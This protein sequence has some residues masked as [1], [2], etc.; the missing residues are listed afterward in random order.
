MS[1]VV[2]TVGR[3]GLLAR[4]LASLAACDPP[5]A[6]LVVVDQSGGGEV[7]AAVAA[8]AC[9]DARRVPSD[10]RSIGAAL[11][12]GLEA[13]RHDIVAVTHDDCE[14]DPSWAGRA[15]ALAARHPGALLTGRVLAAPGPGHVPS[16]TA[17]ATA[18]D[19][20]GELRDNVLYPANMVLDRRAALAIGGFDSRIVPA[21]EDNDFCY[22]WLR[23]GRPLRFE[24]GLVVW[25]ADWRAPEGLAPLYAGYAR[26]AGLFYAKHLRRRDLRVL[27]FLL[28]D[29]RD[30]AR[31]AA[32]AALRRHPEEVDPRRGLWRG[33]PAGL[34]DGWRL[35]G[36]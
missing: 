29:V 13:A 16:T 33:L 1:V 11:N 10:A 20:T 6:E 9:L 14:V 18:R 4:C 17:A 26:G 24:P 7:K 28:R 30:A 15:A 27:R 34:R 3:A 12:A 5:P 23:A 2:P 22:R 21:A 31:G 35:F 25:H 32:S 36:D 19:F 8:V